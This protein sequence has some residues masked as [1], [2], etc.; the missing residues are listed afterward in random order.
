MKFSRKK[1]TFFINIFTF[2][3]QIL[4]P[5]DLHSD[6]CE[7]SLFSKVYEKHAKDVHDYLYYKYGNTL[8]PQDKVQEA[9]I[10]LWV[11]C[12]KVSFNK[13]KSFLL[14]VA[15]NLMLNEYKH[16]KVVLAHQKL[17][18]KD[19]THE[20]PEFLLEKKEYLLQ[21]QKALSKLTEDQRVAF[22]MS[23]IEGKKHSEIAS[24]LGVTQKVVEYRIYSAFDVLRK[25]LQGFS[26]K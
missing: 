20:T 8:N 9:F 17:K 5:K 24:F 19:Y 22:S 4:L 1:I 10:K 3:K 23:K 7:K 12:K 2:L 15:N 16:Q 14:T 6:I 13:A 25:E 26:L 11:N 21:Y 18:P